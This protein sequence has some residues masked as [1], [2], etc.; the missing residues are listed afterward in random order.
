MKSL[1][2]I[3][4]ATRQAVREL[5]E[6][7]KVEPGNRL[8]VGCSTS[9]IKGSKIGSDS[10]MEIANVVLDELMVAAKDYGVFLAIQCCEHLNRAVLIERQALDRE[11]I[12][13]VVPQE[14]AGG[15]LA[16]QAYAK[17]QDPV[18]VEFMQAD[19]GLDIGDTFIGMHMKHVCVPVRLAVKE[20]GQAH[21]TAARVRPKSIGGPRAAYDDRL[22]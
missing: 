1:R 3:Q 13:N 6:A 9:E 15:S 10:S 4:E 7:A 17:F 5:L 19:A 14:H 8:I 2:E 18:M 20:I 11:T 12:V 22:M 16:T 21:V